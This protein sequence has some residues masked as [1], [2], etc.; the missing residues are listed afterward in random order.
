MPCREMNV[1]LVPGWSVSNDV[2]L[3]DLGDKPGRF[4][5]RILRGTVQGYNRLALR[6][7]NAG[8]QCDSRRRIPYIRCSVDQ[9]F[10]VDSSAFNTSHVLKS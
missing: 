10:V 4:F 9:I 5:G 2:P 1:L 7:P 3:F 8:V 6:G